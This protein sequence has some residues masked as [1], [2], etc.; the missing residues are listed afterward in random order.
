ML[1]LSIGVCGKAR[2]FVVDVGLESETYALL[3]VA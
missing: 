2:V 1:I 3:V